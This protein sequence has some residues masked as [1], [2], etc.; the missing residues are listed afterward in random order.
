VPQFEAPPPEQGLSAFLTTAPDMTGGVDT[1][2]SSPRDE[3]KRRVSYAQALRY[4]FLL[5]D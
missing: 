3:E 2:I 1:A 4:S 5:N